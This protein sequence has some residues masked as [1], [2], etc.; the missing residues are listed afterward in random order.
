MYDWIEKC[1]LH[2]PFIFNMIEIIN[3]CDNS[4]LASEYIHELRHKQIQKNQLVFR[5]NIER[6]GQIFAFEISKKLDF[7][8]VQTQTPLGTTN[9]KILHDQPVIASILRAGI[10]LHNGLLDFFDKAENAFISAYRKH[11]NETDFKIQLDYAACPDLNEKVLILADPM[12]AT[13]RSMCDVYKQLKQFG[14][15]RHTHIVSVI[16]AVPG[17]NY[18]K[19]QLAGEQVT[20]W[21]AAI[22][23]ELNAHS[24]IVPGLGDAG[25]LSFG[26]KI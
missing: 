7:K 11:L 23:P 16:S 13:A 24:Y 9:S 8:S 19:E 21:T 25:D 14:Q 22:D 26:D 20:V 5:K 1:N 17:I 12:L 15:A 3:I 18:L 2:Q 4:S 6:L 10:P